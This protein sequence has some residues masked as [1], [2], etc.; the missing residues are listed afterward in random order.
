[1]QYL[2][3]DVERQSK[4]NVTFIPYAP[5]ALYIFISK[6]V[7]IYPDEKKSLITIG[8]LIYKRQYIILSRKISRFCM[9]EQLMHQLKRLNSS[10]F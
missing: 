3:F 6:S 9:T 2:N 10:E 1:M 7:Y 5:D 4:S 8:K